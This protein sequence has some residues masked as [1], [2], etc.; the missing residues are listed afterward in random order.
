MWLPFD[1]RSFR[2]LMLVP[3][4][5]SLC[6]SSSQFIY[7]ETWEM[8]TFHIYTQSYDANEKLDHPVNKKIRNSNQTYQVPEARGC[9]SWAKAD[10]S[11]LLP[12]PQ[13]KS[14]RNEVCVLKNLSKL[15]EDFVTFRAQYKL[16]TNQS[17]FTSISH[18]VHYIKKIH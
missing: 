11:P 2:S 15:K 18:Q 12:R 5:S 1:V 3:S 13:K 7:K 4:F 17:N 10:G 8:C 6:L 14:I 9:V 16:N